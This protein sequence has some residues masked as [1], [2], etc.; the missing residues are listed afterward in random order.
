M[1]V[2]FEWSGRGSRKVGQ[3][4]LEKEMVLLIVSQRQFIFRVRPL[5]YNVS[6]MSICMAMKCK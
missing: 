6:I 4:L 1:R 2:N 3:V 5:V